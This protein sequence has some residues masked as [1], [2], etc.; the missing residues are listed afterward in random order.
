MSAAADLLR[1]APG[2]PCIECGARHRTWKTLAQCLYPR[3]RKVYDDFGTGPWAAVHQFRQPHE[4]ADCPD[5]SLFPTQEQAQTWLDGE[6]PGGRPCCGSCA[7]SGRRSVVRVGARI[8]GA[9][10]FKA[11]RRGR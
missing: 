1:V 2:V 8:F 10:P 4:R 6:H 11:W 7:R 9:S 3:A 5:L